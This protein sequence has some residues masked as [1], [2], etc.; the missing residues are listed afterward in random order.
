MYERSINEE[1]VE[2]VI[3][4]GVIIYEYADDKTYP[5]ILM[6]C[7]N[8]AKPLHVVFSIDESIQKEKRYLV[9]TVYRPSLEEWNSDYVTRRVDK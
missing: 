1:E 5:S 4:N 8:N 7:T 2:Y 3:E 6:Y 9:I